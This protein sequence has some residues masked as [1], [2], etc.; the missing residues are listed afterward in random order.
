AT[1]DARPTA[2]R[3]RRAAAVCRTIYPDKAPCPSPSVRRRPAAGS[4]RPREFSN[5]TSGRRA[6][7]GTVSGRIAPASSARQRGFAQQALQGFAEGRAVDRV[8]E[9]E[10]DK[11]LEVAGEITDVVSLLRRRKLDGHHAPAFL[12]EQANGVG[13][14]Y[15]AAPVG[16]NAPDAVEDHRGKYV[17]AGNGEVARGLVG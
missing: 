12:A 9:R 8:G 4:L 15:L 3:R 10:L 2:G 1:L 6:A 11:C 5:G 16:I 7:P 13:H 14:L 17:A